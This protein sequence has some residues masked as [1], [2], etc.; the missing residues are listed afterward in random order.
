MC[1]DITRRQH[2]HHPATAID[3]IPADGTLRIQADVYQ[4][5]RVLDNLPG[6]ARQAAPSGRIRV[7]LSASG[8]HAEIRVID[9][10]P[11]FT[12]EAREHLFEPFHT[13]KRGGSGLGL[14]SCLAIVQAHG[15]TMAVGDGPS[16]EVIVRLPAA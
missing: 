8:K 4:L 12:A 16:G 1:A 15:G 11:G 3:F 2:D 14:A 6:N 13:T 10:G 9:S 7:D 5:E